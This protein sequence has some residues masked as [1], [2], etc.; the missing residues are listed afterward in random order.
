MAPRRT[1]GYVIDHDATPEDFARWDSLGALY[2]ECRAKTAGIE[3]RPRMFIL[4]NP[5]L[6]DPH[7]DAEKIRNYKRMADYDVGLTQFIA[8]LTTW[9]LIIRSDKVGLPHV[10]YS[11]DGLQQRA[12]ARLIGHGVP[13]RRKSRRSRSVSVSSPSPS[14]GAR[15]DWDETVSGGH[16]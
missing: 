4:L 1:P 14:V 10:N 8:D 3:S 5:E 7:P 6:L 9:R 16:S 2:C 15:S 13:T 12:W 11:S